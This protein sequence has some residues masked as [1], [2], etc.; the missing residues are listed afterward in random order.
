[1]GYPPQKFHSNWSIETTDMNLSLENPKSIDI[2]LQ[3]D[4]S[5]KTC[6]IIH[7]LHRASHKDSK[8]SSFSIL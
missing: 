4:F 1:M 2:I 5:I 8:T 6:K 7:V 3:Q